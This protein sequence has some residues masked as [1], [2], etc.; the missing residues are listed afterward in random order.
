[1]TMNRVRLGKRGEEMAA[2]YLKS[3][4]YGI[5]ASNYPVPVGRD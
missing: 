4:G 3:A 2:G 5:L 1:M